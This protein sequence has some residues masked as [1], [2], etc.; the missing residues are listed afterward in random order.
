M[1]NELYDNVREIYQN[2][3]LDY[4]FESMV[5]DFL[6]LIERKLPKD[7]EVKDILMKYGFLG[8]IAV[9]DLKKIITIINTALKD[10]NVNKAEKK[11]VSQEKNIIEKAIIAYKLKQINFKRMPELLKT[12][13][14]VWP[15]IYRYLDGIFSEFIEYDKNIRVMLASFGK[16][17]EKQIDSSNSVTMQLIPV[18]GLP[19]ALAIDTGSDCGAGK[20]IRRVIRDD[21]YIYMITSEDY[22]LPYGYIGLFSVDVNGD[23]VLWVDAINPSTQLNIDADEF[24]KQLEEHFKQILENTEFKAVLV[25]SDNA[26]ISNRASVEQAFDKMHLQASTNVFG[27]EVKALADDIEKVI[28]EK[29]LLKYGFEFN[30]SKILNDIYDISKLS[31]KLRLYLDRI[32]D[33]LIFSLADLDVVSKS[34]YFQMKKEIFDVYKNIMDILYKYSHLEVVDDYIKGFD[35]DNLSNIDDSYEEWIDLFDDVFMFEDSF[36][37]FSARITYEANK[38]IDSYQDITDTQLHQQ[39]YDSRVWIMK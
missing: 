37:N 16:Y 14:E 18:K 15:D 2:G 11:I 9:D 29:F 22:S 30:K 25:S 33:L 32:K 27:H 10:K 38:L 5:K 3:V 6:N 7:Q 35:I 34:Q 23:N 19:A 36:Q 39:A 28:S 13:Q 21:M 8:D 17:F 12:L 26:L 31:Q 1:F 24:V 20:S 4:G